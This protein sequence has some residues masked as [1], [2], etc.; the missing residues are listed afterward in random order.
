MGTPYF[1]DESLGEVYNMKD[2][3]GEKFLV[4]D[5]LKVI[6]WAQCGAEDLEVGDVVECVYNDYTSVCVSSSYCLPNKDFTTT[7]TYRNSKR[8]N[9][10]D[11]NGEE[12]LVGD[13]LKVIKITNST[14]KFSVGDVVQCIYDDE[15]SACVFRNLKDGKEGFFFNDRLQKL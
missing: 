13:K 8:Y 5:S 14:P 7:T 15:T 9:M 3:N 4:G 10:Q 6:K 11:I 12:F 2:I 1:G